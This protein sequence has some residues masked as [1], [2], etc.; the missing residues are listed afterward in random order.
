MILDSRKTVADKG[1]DN[2]RSRRIVHGEKLVD[3]FLGTSASSYQF[4]GSVLLMLPR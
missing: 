4:G 3:T 1:R 2:S